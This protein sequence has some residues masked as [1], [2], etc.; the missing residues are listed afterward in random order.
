MATAKVLH[1][2]FRGW[3]HV[4]KSERARLDVKRRAWRLVIEDLD[5]DVGLVSLR[6]PFPFRTIVTILQSIYV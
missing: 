4:L 6:S 3:F 5:I 1:P 2:G